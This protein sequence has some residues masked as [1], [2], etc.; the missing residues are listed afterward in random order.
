MFQS[1]QWNTRVSEGEGLW[2]AETF[3]KAIVYNDRGCS[4]EVDLTNNIRWVEESWNFND[5]RNM[6]ADDQ[7]NQPI[8]IDDELNVAIFNMNKPWYQQQRIRGGYGAIR[9]IVSPDRNLT[10][11]LNEALSKFRVSPR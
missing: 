1:F 2:E 6:I 10:L 8:F 5:F 3:D 11:Y 4:N 7:Q 9:L